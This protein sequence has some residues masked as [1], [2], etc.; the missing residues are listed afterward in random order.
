LRLQTPTIDCGHSGS[1]RPSWSHDM[2][3]EPLTAGGGPRNRIGF[4]LPGQSLEF[5]TRKLTDNRSALSIA[6]APVVAKGAHRT[7]WSAAGKR[8]HPVNRVTLPLRRIGHVAA[9][10]HRSASDA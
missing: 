9:T 1:S 8:R 5:Q 2:L 7:G 3:S 6:S 10:D 4:L